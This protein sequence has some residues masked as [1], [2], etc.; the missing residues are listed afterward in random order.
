MCSVFFAI[1][2]IDGLD[3]DT[4]NIYLDRNF[5]NDFS[6]EDEGQPPL[7]FSPD[8]AHKH[9]QLNLLHKKDKNFD[10][11]LYSLEAGKLAFDFDLPNPN[12][13]FKV[14]NV[15]LADTLLVKIANLPLSKDENI[16]HIWR[17]IYKRTDGLSASLELGYGGFGKQWF[18]L[19]REGGDERVKYSHSFRTV[20]LGV[21]VQYAIKNINFGVIGIYEKSEIGGGIRS[22]ETTVSG[23]SG[24]FARNRL[25]YGLTLGYDIKLSGIFS[26]Q[27]YVNGLRYQYV[28]NKRNAQNHT[29]LWAYGAGIKI[30]YHV[31]GNSVLYFKM[32]YSQ[33]YFK[34]PAEL[35]RDR[36][37]DKVYHEYRLHRRSH[38]QMNFAL[39]YRFFVTKN[40]RM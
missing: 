28:G 4:P 40:K 11:P 33:N 13:T 26:M 19:K 27:P 38:K 30:N 2:L 35:I 16:Y 29:H 7:Q 32:G 34:V 21:E 6:L 15:A 39:G 9:V 20:H 1:V 18:V 3:T 24:T 25:Y 37:Y 5:N 10:L 22:G 14:N 31:G 8:A 36:F 17:N 23:L 12:F